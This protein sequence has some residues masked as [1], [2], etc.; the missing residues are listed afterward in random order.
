M[1][2][3]GVAREVLEVRQRRVAEVEIADHSDAWMHQY[4]ARHRVVVSKAGRTWVST[5][6]ITS[7][8]RPSGLLWR[9]SSSQRA[10]R[11]AAPSGILSPRK[12]AQNRR[13]NAT[14]N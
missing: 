5:W 8:S 1:F 12:P 6:P 3:L 10:A 14:A 9:A 2:E 11:S 4:G 7:Y 13:A